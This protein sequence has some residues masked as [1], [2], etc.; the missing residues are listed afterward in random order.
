M[1]RRRIDEA[2]NGG[3]AGTTS[4]AAAAV[5]DVARIRRRRRPLDGPT[6]RL[7][8]QKVA[9]RACSCSLRERRRR[10]RNFWPEHE[11]RGKTTRHRAD[12]AVPDRL[13][14]TRS[15]NTPDA[16]P[17]ASRGRS[18]SPIWH[19][20]D[21]RRPRRDQPIQ[22]TSR[23]R[24][25]RGAL[26]SADLWL[27]RARSRASFDEARPTLPRG[28]FITDPREGRAIEEASRRSPRNGAETY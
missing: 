18:S 3:G 7:R 19:R 6:G 11:D 27:S 22:R 8:S 4:T 14:R 17:G 28:T 15:A 9:Q 5:A 25:A 2:D 10:S 21:G 20:V 23:P 1:T 12:A 16:L 26:D 24:R 13:V